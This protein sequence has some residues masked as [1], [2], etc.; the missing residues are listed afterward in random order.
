MKPRLKTKVKLERFNGLIWSHVVIIIYRI[1]RTYINH[2]Y[3]KYT[4]LLMN[5]SL[6]NFYIHDIFVDLLDYNCINF[7]AC[8]LFFGA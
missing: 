5:E 2:C 4:S 6:I 3:F 7:M 8:G 1:L